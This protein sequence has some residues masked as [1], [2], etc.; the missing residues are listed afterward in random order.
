[1]IVKILSSASNFAGIHYNERKNDAG[2]SEL[3]RAENF[4]SLALNANPTKADYVNYLKAF[5]CS[6]TRI[7][8]IQFHAVIS[9]KGK[10]YPLD[11]L[12]DI[13]VQYLQAM[14]YGSNPFLIYHHTDTNHRH[15]HL[16]STRVDGDGKKVDDRFE[17][18]R[19]QKVMHEILMRDPH[20]EAD[21]CLAEAMKY[22]FSTL[23]QFKL[24]LE[25]KGFKVQEV[26][27]KLSMIK[28]GNVQLLL[29]AG[30]IKERMNAYVFPKKRARQLTAIIRKYAIDKIDDQWAD[31]M[32]KKFG[33]NIVFHRKQG[34]DTPYGYTIIDHPGKTVFKGSQILGLAELFS[35]PQEKRVTE[36]VREMAKQP[37]LSFHDFQIELS[38]IGV[39]TYDNGS[40]SWNAGNSQ[41]SLEELKK[42]R[43]YQRLHIA[44]EFKMNDASCKSLLG[45]A[46]LINPDE[47]NSSILSN[48]KFETHRA[49]MEY[50]DQS[51]R[52]E[53]G[54]SHF[55]YRLLRDDQ[56][57][58]LFIP[59]EPALI[60]VE[61]LLG[62][63][64]SISPE[65]IPHINTMTDLSTNNELLGHSSKESILEALIGIM[66][67][68]QQRPKEDKDNKR[69]TIKL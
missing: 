63:P 4:G 3:L 28:Y 68:A 10:D 64:P 55:N 51:N 41:L 11:K 7:K 62:R 2:D 27:G 67:E 34:Y 16:I 50:L 26:G 31:F 5:C 1:M 18:L 49:A 57:I 20:Y 42:L 15:I 14:G 24:L 61:K 43:Y 39:R 6:N 12:S 53:E 8:K 58:F 65:L 37:N 45:K 9:A 17:K 69:K 46:L 22:Q 36:L 47:L 40:Y 54:L 44:S 29:E 59:A 52:W 38:K 23:P 30:P 66:A 25:L 60:Q 32:K 13:G 33:V 56:R 19:S 35:A 48:Q 21:Q